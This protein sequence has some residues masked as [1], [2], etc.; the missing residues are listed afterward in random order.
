MKVLITGAA[1][2]IGFH[3]AKRLLHEGCEVIGIDDHNDYY[4]PA[5][6]A[7][8]ETQLL[9]QSRYLSVRG[10]IETPGLLQDLF[11]THR[12]SIVVH[13][14]A[15]AGVRHSITHPEAYLS[16]NILGSYHLLE[17]ARAY[18]PRHMLMASS[19]SVYGGNSKM[20]FRET[21]KADLPLSLYGATKKSGEMMAH[22]YSGLFNLPIT[23]FRFFTV[24]GPW[25][26]PDMAPHLFTKA[27][28]EQRPIRLFNHGHMMRDFTY[29]DDLIAAI[30]ALL[31]VVPPAPGTGSVAE[32]DS[33]SPMAPWRVVNIGNGSP[34]ALLR[35]VRALER[36]SGQEAR[37]DLMPMQAGDVEATW[38]DTSLLTR[39]TGS[40]RQT[41]IE[42]GAQSFIEWFRGYYQIG[43][44]NYPRLH[45][46]G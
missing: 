29:I 44:E 46:T 10:K 18:P 26:R 33:L 15:Q 2:F 43:R 30:L 6:K 17:A 8:R 41:D 32:W 16:S 7:A 22:A 37:F 40:H 1:G 27:L 19:S 35:F 42:G 39:L 23:M 31:D 5:L 20:P 28:F 13:L 3:L 4:D 25:G 9:Q 36:A 14:A 24:Y 21:D 11:A 45:K 34:V 12:P 38:A